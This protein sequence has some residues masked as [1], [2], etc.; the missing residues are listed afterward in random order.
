MPSSF[1]GG[2][3][4]YSIEGG[5]KTVTFAQVPSPGFMTA[6]LTVGTIGLRVP[7][8]TTTWPR[9][10]IVKQGTTVRRGFAVTPFFYSAVNFGGAY[11]NEAIPMEFELDAF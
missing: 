11:M 2:M 5:P 7:T 6:S 1:I 3:Q 4:F 9:A 8:F 10:Q